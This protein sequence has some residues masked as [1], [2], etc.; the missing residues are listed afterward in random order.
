MKNKHKNFA[1]EYRMVV[2]QFPVP[3]PCTKCTDDKIHSCSDNP[4]PC[5][6]FDHYIKSARTSE[7]PFFMYKRDPKPPKPI[8]IAPPDREYNWEDE[9]Q[10]PLELD[11]ILLFG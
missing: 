11:E 1:Q 2:K 5:D 3:P 6:K 4:I 8:D 10:K 7:L 9:K